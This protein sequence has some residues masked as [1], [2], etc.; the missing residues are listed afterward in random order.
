LLLHRLGPQRIANGADNVLVTRRADGR[1]VVAVWNLWPPNQQGEEREVELEFSGVQG[2]SR[3]GVSRI[4]AQH[5]NTLATWRRMGSPRY[6][7]EKQV[8]RMNRESALGNAEMM[9][10]KDGKLQIKLPV[11]GFAL[12]E[13][14]R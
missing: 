10:L 12:I 11:N 3:V 4:D 2:N 7:T 8:E 1:L 5:G 14:D 6:P 13:A 9:K